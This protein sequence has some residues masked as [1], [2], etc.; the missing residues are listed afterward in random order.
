MTQNRG[1]HSVDFFRRVRD[2]HSEVLSLMDSEE[3]IRFFQSASEP[4]NSATSDR[5]L[6]GRR[7]SSEQTARGGVR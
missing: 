2:K 1:F 3:I 5:V 4:N 7:S 6:S